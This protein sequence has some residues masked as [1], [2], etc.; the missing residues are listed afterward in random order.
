[1]SKKVFFLCCTKGILFLWL[2]SILYY[3]VSYREQ[4][5]VGK[6]TV[7]VLI[8]IAISVV[9][10]LIIDF[11][12][13]L[14]L[15]FNS[16]V[17]GCSILVTIYC[18][19]AAHLAMFYYPGFPEYS[20]PITLDANLK[21]L[22]ESSGVMLDKRTG[23]EVV[24]DYRSRGIDAY[25]AF[26]VNGRQEWGVKSVR[27][28][29]I[30]PLG[31][32]S[33]KLIVHCNES[34][35][36]SIYHSDEK[37]F[38]NPP[39][40]WELL[41]KEK[42]DYLLLGDSFVHGACVG[43]NEDYGAILRSYSKNVVNLGQRGNGPLLNLAGLIEY[44]IEIKPSKIL[45]F[46]TEGND[47]KNLRAE[48][49]NPFI[50]RYLLD[51]FGQRLSARVEEVDKIV[52][53]MT[54]KHWARI[55]ELEKTKI[56]SM[57]KYWASLRSIRQR[58]GLELPRKGHEGAK[59]IKNAI[60]LLEAGE[61]NLDVDRSDQDKRQS[62]TE[63]EDRYTSEI[64]LFREILLK[65]KSISTKWDGEIVFVYMP[66]GE[67][68]LDKLRPPGSL[69]DFVIEMVSS[70]GI[71]V[72]DLVPAFYALNDPMEAFPFRRGGHYNSKGYA[73]SGEYLFKKL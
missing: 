19:E 7:V 23:F 52:H 56:S 62:E 6:S 11:F 34:G 48:A 29:Q 39:G 45:W 35:Y 67:R 31:G 40:S 1:M 64:T 63:L 24:R 59:K 49:Q 28:G 30:W 20:P 8:I 13:K 38:N 42:T 10:L 22:A 53:K 36:W 33:N 61:S 65:A 2:L 66:S 3:L 46:Y 5:I 41:S 15:Q 58:F 25:P 68:F 60:R 54:N 50:S 12:R 51:G 47:L 72:I 21:R 32:H 55:D 4:L 16:T 70:T 17:V 14:D 73:I 27:D 18:V 57:F 69:K 26:M 37:G 44:G 71:Q 43:E 9:I